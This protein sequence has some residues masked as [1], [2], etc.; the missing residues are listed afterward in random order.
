MRG[1]SALNTKFRSCRV[2]R[3]FPYAQACTY[4]VGICRVE[5]DITMLYEY[6]NNVF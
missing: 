5:N 4:T 6:K 2:D 3:L 1:T